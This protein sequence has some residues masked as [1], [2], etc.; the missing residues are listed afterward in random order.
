MSGRRGLRALLAMVLG[1]T[2]IGILVSSPPASA[3]PG[4]EALTD[5]AVTVSGRD[6]FAGLKVTVSQTKNL[7]NQTVTVSWT[8]G[9][10]TL[11]L[12]GFS[13]NYLQ[14][15][16][17]WGDEPQGPDRT[18][19]QFGGGVAP[20]LQT[21]AW[22]RVRQL[23]YPFVDP[24]ET[25]ELP[26]GSPAGSNAFVPFWP[27]GGDKPASAVTSGRNDFFNAQ[28][29]NE[30]PLARTRGDGTGLEHFEV[31]TVRQAAGLGCG[32]PVT[33]DGATGRKCWLVVVPRGSTEV[34]GSPRSGTPGA[35]SV[36]ES[37]P[38]STSNWDNRIVFPLE[39]L[40]VGQA[41]PLG[42]PERRVVGHELAVEAVGRWQPALCAGGGA[43]YSYTQLPDG[44]TRT[45]CSMA[46]R[47]AWR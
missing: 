41:C 31:Q 30:I 15:M 24:Q 47:L 36:L 14:I 10:P 6:E 9:L 21:G 23:T 34:D 33:T 35:G 26:A 27:V 46:A 3:A 19:C 25:L 42:A 38:L 12:G 43:L 17:C 20:N 32:A 16:Q 4:D 8:G 18:Q 29:T 37:S 39:F 7:I 22:T 1:A 2:M 13:T 5:S 11:P 40:P 28:L 45:K 44:V